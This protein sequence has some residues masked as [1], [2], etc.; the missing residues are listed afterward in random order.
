MSVWAMRSSE[1]S[2]MLNDC[3]PMPMSRTAAATIR[4][5]ARSGKGPLFRRAARG[6]AGSAAAAAA[7]WDPPDRS[8]LSTPASARQASGRRRA[9]PQPPDEISRRQ[10][11]GCPSMRPRRAP[12]LVTTLERRLPGGGYYECSGRETWWVRRTLARSSCPATPGWRRP[13]GWGPAPGCGPMPPSAPE[14]NWAPNASSESAPSSTP[15]CGSAAAA[16][17]RTRPSSTP[18][19]MIEDGV[20]IGPAAILT[21]DRYPARHH[22]RGRARRRPG[23]GLRRGWWCATVPASAPAPW[24]WPVS[25]SAPG[26]WSPPAPSSPG[27]FPAHALVAGSRARRDR[28]GGPFGAAARAR[29]AKEPL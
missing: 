1:I 7:V 3:C 14:P 26:P 16:R 18:R 17:S 20:F 19:R 29:T 4:M 27:P 2:S 23:I 21:N 12:R 8:P 15:G 24:S 9:P 6:A 25:R 11:Q 22:P 28:L 10:A 13:R 5:R